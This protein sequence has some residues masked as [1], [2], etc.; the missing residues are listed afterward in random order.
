M[1]DEKRW[2][3]NAWKVINAIK[4]VPFDEREKLIKALFDAHA[5]DGDDYSAGRKVTG[6]GYYKV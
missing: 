4:N 2:S 5:K 1:A 6:E 3:E